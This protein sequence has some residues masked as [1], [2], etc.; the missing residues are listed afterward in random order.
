M[1]YTSTIFEGKKLPNNGYMYIKNRDSNDVI[2][3]RCVER[4]LCN[5]RITTYKSDGSVKK[6]PTIHNHPPD[7]VAL[8]TARTIGE[9]K[10]RAT[11]TEE[12]T[13]SVIQYC[14]KSISIAAAV[15]LP[16]KQNSAKIVRRKRKAPEE[17]FS[18][19]VHTRRGEQFRKNATP[20]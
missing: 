2:Y 9:I 4:G 16:S 15:K 13:S 3:W 12:A 7:N 8:E 11:L 5:A 18:E 19:S 6:T 10:M 17:D 20:I 1:E 14:T